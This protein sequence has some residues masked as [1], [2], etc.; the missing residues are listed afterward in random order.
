M[1][2]HLTHSASFRDPSG[3]VFLKKGIVYR[4][5]NHSYAADYELLMQ[6][7]LYQRLTEEKLL[8]PHTEV[9]ENLTGSPHWYKTLL[10][11][12]LSFISYAYEWSFAQLRE[13]ADLT[14]KILE[15][16]IA[17]GMCLKDANSF[18][19][20]FHEGALLLIDTLSF[21]KHDTSRPWVAYRQFCESLLFPLYLSHYLKTDLQKW[22]I[23]YPE[24]IPVALINRL[25]PAKSRLSLG[26]WLHVYL[27]NRIRG[28]NP[29]GNKSVSFTR[30]KMQMLTRHLR[31]EVS[32]M[33]LSEETISPWSNYYD[34]TILGGGYLHEKEIIFKAFLEGI[35]FGSAL[36]IGANN[37]YFSKILAEAGK[38]V[39]AIDSDHQCIDSLY[40][41]VCGNTDRTIIPLCVDIANPSP[42]IGFRN[43]ERPSFIQRARV[44]LVS[45][46]A[47]THHLV[48]GKNIPLEGIAG[49]LADLTNSYLIVEYIPLT[50]KFAQQLIKAKSQYHSP[51]DEPTF[52]N[53]FSHYFVIERKSR[54]PGTER[55]LYRMRK[56]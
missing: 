1:P 17:Y 5:V 34:E 43:T 16:A 55:V 51:Y 36:D 4:Q 12:Q 44:D 22:L 19:I 29:A 56:C 40:R 14:L 53:S 50:D 45:A 31:S 21:E 38:N 33:T 8:I 3:F 2:G 28:D 18:N 15:I 20:Q 11:Q 48:L 41:S 24:G 47:I 30:E 7:G 25:L 35:D 42:A 10:P 49:L 6:S 23:V 27:Q 46:L 26:P 52:E 39:I 37:G 32:R 9:D 54:I 13:A